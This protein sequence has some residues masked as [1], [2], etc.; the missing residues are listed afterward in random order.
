MEKPALSS[1][2]DGDHSKEEGDGT[3]PGPRNLPPPHGRALALH[4]KAALEEPS[5][6]WKG[7]ILARLM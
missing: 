4:Q 5:P 1:P 6:T 3:E 2:G 7:Y